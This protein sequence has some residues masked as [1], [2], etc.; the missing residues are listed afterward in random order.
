MLAV[1]FWAPRFVFFFFFFFFS[2]ETSDRLSKLPNTWFNDLN[3]HRSFLWSVRFLYTHAVDTVFF[4]IFIYIFLNV[5]K[6]CSMPKPHTKIYK[7]MLFYVFD[8]VQV[9][10]DML[11]C[12]SNAYMFVLHRFQV[13][14]DCFAS[15]NFYVFICVARENAFC[16]QTVEMTVVSFVLCS[17]FL[18]NHLR[19]SFE[20]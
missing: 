13:Y 3:S 18:A 10:C 11:H 6:S 1:Y 17:H 20:K 15:C 8:F 2:V 4:N 14:L 7:C 16:R 19:V 12:I 9:I 5:R